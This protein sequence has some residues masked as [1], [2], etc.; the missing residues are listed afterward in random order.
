MRASLGRMLN[1]KQLSP[2][3]QV[4]FYYLRLLD[5]SKKSG[6]ERKP[7]ETPGQFASQLEQFIPDVQDDIHNM[8]DAFVE[9][10][11]SHHSISS[12]HTT[13]VQRMWRKIAQRLK[14]QRSNE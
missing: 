9:A 11:Y 5:R 7:Y 12:D 6:V 8:T 4:I 10:R 14:P 2:R 13:A 3:Q 1:F